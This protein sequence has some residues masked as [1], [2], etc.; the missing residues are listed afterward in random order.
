[1]EDKLLTDAQLTALRAAY[2]SIDTVLPERL[3]SFRKIFRGMSLAQVRQVATAQPPLPASF[4]TNL[5]RNL[6][7][8][9][10]FLTLDKSAGRW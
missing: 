7:P 8:H 3:E 4:E 6:P 5:I 10:T 1:M 9:R 2:D